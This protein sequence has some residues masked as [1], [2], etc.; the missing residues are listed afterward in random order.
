MRAAILSLLLICLPAQS[1]PVSQLA[2]FQV[3]TVKPLEPNVRYM[4]GVEVHPG[5]RV[6][7]T[8]LPLKSLIVIAFRLSHWQVS[9][10]E[11]WIQ[12]DRYSIEA[13]PPDDA[14]IQTLRYTNSE[15]DDEQLREMLQSLLIDRFQLRFHR[16]TRTGD[17]YELSRNG[18]TLALRP[19][20][21]PQAADN[22]SSR[23]LYWGSIGYAGG[24]WVLTNTAMAQLAKFAADNVLRVPV[25]DRTQLAGPYDYRQAVPDLEPNYTDNTDSFLHMLSDVGLKLER[26][27]GPIEMFAIDSAMKPSPQIF[28][29]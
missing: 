5:G 23:R 25:L 11:S 16:E 15:I 7:V 21:I 19:T 28:R 2:E 27:K 20:E 6:V 17:V 10:G 3:A 12:N 14:K 4:A 18:K 24:R 13:K 9:G 1:K 29:R 26:S 22:P 8:G